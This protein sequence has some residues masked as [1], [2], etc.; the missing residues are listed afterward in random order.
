MKCEK[1]NREMTKSEILTYNAV[2]AAHKAKPDMFGPPLMYCY[3]CQG[4]APLMNEI[5]NLDSSKPVSKTKS[6]SFLH[7]TGA[8]DFAGYEVS[9]AV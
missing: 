7:H 3:D 5:E 2:M 6:D 4:L 8:N 9:Y 1:C